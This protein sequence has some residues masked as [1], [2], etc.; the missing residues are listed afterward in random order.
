[1]LTHTSYLVV[2]ALDTRLTLK[3]IMV[4][5]SKEFSYRFSKPNNQKKHDRDIIICI[6]VR[7]KI[8]KELAFCL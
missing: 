5:I 3:L 6:A 7:F 4:K 2:L 8:F 1:M